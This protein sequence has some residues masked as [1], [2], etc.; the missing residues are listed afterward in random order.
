M[1]AC[2]SQAIAAHTLNIFYSN[3]QSDRLPR[4]NVG[5]YNLDIVGNLETVFALGGGQSPGRSVF[6]LSRP[7]ASQRAAKKKTKPVFS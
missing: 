7:L 3:R 4:A 1:L 2:L 6:A 5:F